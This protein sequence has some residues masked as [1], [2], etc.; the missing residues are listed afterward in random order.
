[1]ISRRLVLARVVLAVM[2]AALSASAHAADYPDRPIKVLHGFGAGGPPDTVLRLIAKRLESSLGKPVVIENHPG[3]SGTI[4]A[5]VVARAVPD[6]YT[7][8]FGVAANLAVAP[9]TMKPAPYDP[10]AAF[11]PIVEVA[12]GPYLWLVRSDAPAQNMKEFVAGARRRP[13]ELHYGTPGIASVHHFAT[14]ML[15]RAAGISMTQVPYTSSPYTALLG[16]QIDAMFESLPGPLPFLESGKLRALAVSGPKRLARL[17]EVPTLAEQGIAGVDASSWWG[18]VG[19][20]GLPSPI[21]ER[22]NL[23]VRNALRDPEIMESLQR[24]GIEPTPSTSTAFGSFIAEENARWTR[25]ARSI[26]VAGS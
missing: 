8:L 4:A 26:G 11:Q 16:G 20:A 9:A 14:E 15:Q 1:V 13:G 18:F 19:P 5:S 24:L 3:A 10:V 17:P 22:L 6:G 21:V 2:S 23:E 25:M 12:R 7:L